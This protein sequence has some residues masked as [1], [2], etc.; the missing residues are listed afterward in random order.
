MIRQ[1]YPIARSGAW[2]CDTVVALGDVTG[3]GV[4]LAKNSD[5]RSHEAQR[6]IGASAARHPVTAVV[7]MPIC[8]SAP[9][10][11]EQPV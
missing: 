6:L 9:G 10:R 1:G 8:H 7:A 3:G 5:R 2:S 4:L 11:A